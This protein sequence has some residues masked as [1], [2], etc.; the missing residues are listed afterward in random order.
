LMAVGLQEHEAHTSAIFAHALD[1]IVMIDHEGRILD[2]NPAAERTFGHA[3]ERVLGRPLAEVIFPP[4]LRAAHEGGFAHHLATG[5]SRVLGRRIEVSALRADGTEFPVELAITRLPGENARLVGFLRDITE[6]KHADLRLAAH[7][8]LLAGVA[9]GQ[10]LAVS[11]DAICCFVESQAQGMLCSVLVLDADGAHLRNGAA[12]SLPAAYCAAI[13]GV[14][15]GPAAGSCGTAAFRREA[16]TVSDIATDPLWENYKA[17]ALAHGLRACWSTPILGSDGAVLG[18]FAMYYPTVREPEP[19]H[20]QLIALATQT[21]ALAFQREHADAALRASE[22]RFRAIFT[23]GPECVKVVSPAGQL[24]EMNAAG[25]VMFEV[26]SLAEVQARPLL[27]WIVAAHRVAFSQLHAQVMR[28]ESGSL[29]FEIIGASGTRRWVHTHA[30]PLRDEQGN[31]RALLGITGDITERKSAEAALRQSEE[32]FA[33]AYRSSPVA[34][35]I[36]A[37]AD[38]RLIDVNESF[39]RLFGHER[40]EDLLGRTAFELGLWR[41]P[42]ERERLRV[43]L[44]QSGSLKQFETVFHKQSGELGHA[45]ASVERIELQGEPCS[46][47]IIYDITARK[48]AEALLEASLDGLNEGVMVSE[49]D[50]HLVRWNRAALRMHD[51]ATLDECRRGL[52]EFTDTF[53]LLAS[54]GGEVPFAQWPIERILRGETVHEWE[55]R[56]RHKRAGWVKLIVYSGTL[57]RDAAGSP[58]LALLTMTNITERRQ[59]EEQ[60]RQS[61]K[62]DAIGQ[63]AGGVAHDFNNILTAITLHAEL[64]SAHPGL[65]AEVAETLREISSASDRAAS[66]T[67]QLLLFSRQQV[68]QVRHFNFSDAVTTSA[69]LL[70]RL[71]GEDVRLDLILHPRPLPICADE[72]MLGQVL[73]NLGIN[74]RDAMPHGGG[75]LIETTERVVGAEEAQLHPGTAPGRYACLR[76]QD[77]GQGIAPVVLPRIF[78]PFFSTKAVGKGTGLGLA[79]VFGVVQQHRGWIDV[80][81]KLDKGTTFLV[82]LPLVEPPVQ[83][84]KTKSAVAMPRGSETILLVEDENAVRY[85]VRVMLERHGYRLLVAEHG[86]AALALWQLEHGKIDLLLTDLV[87]PGGLGGRELAAQLQTESPAL[88][89]IVM[90]GYSADLAGRDLVLPTRQRFLQKPFTLDALLTTVRSA[91]DAH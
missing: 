83:V 2:F 4:A 41:D 28:G 37:M 38:G 68:M 16:V 22:A 31:I 43:D 46:L 54:D 58:L 56:L 17:L 40:R 60:L 9:T 6:R 26:A 57:V 49:L 87:M 90:S 24:L 70:K 27:E 85:T 84:E 75:L 25:F 72:G 47:S 11:L 62:M 15:I 74:A 69:K 82:F 86:P 77:T 14:A 36:S 76:V 51:Y 20:R 61:Q 55:V 91:L 52:P 35:L 3:R 29:E 59:L 81:S 65:P 7:R 19:E 79:T 89:V 53:E 5:E 50:G 10:S 33:K 66:L 30:A 45:L 42:A 67:N 48:H 21:A 18:T 8:D 1:C 80:E 23:T 64:A 39:V 13:D 32:R 12:P 73:L 88:K 63:L 44:A 71:L 34:M 78:E